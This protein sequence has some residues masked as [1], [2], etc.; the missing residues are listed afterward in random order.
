MIPGLCGITSYKIEAHNASF[1][2]LQNIQQTEELSSMW[3]T[4]WNRLGVLCILLGFA[5]G[6]A[7]IF[8]LNLLIIFSIILL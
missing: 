1:Y 4:I 3:L 7:N 5:L 2:P 8:H 6:I